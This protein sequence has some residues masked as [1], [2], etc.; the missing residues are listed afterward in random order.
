M[1]FR[2]IA[3]LALLLIVAAPL[4]RA[5]Q[6]DTT[7]LAELEKQA[8][9]LDRSA[10]EIGHE[11]IYQNLSTEFDIPVDMLR[12]QRVETDFGFGELFIAN[13]LARASGQDFGVL[14][15][16]RQDGKGWGVIARENGVKL[17]SVV[18]RIQRANGAIERERAARRNTRMDGPAG[19]ADRSRQLNRQQA[20]PA[21]RGRR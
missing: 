8:E 7:D 15:Q 14:A 18:S 19:K 6:T 12:S 21:G 9:A 20:N 2:S 16:Q 13:S 3:V 4:V 11:K 10:S 5:A 1:A 17:G